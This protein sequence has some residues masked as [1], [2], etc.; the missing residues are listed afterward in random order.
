MEQ[1]GGYKYN[2][3]PPTIQSFGF[4]VLSLFSPYFSNFYNNEIIIIIIIIEK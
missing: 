3:S 1:R 2:L 4:S